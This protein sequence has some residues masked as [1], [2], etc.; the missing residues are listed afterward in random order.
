M[1]LEHPFDEMVL[2]HS[3]NESNFAVRSAT[4][5]D[6]EQLM[7]LSAETVPSNGITLSYERSSKLFSGEPSTI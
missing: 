4:P 1:F 6:D 7:K 5:A 2:Y 3:K